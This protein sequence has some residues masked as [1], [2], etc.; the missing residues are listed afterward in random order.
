MIND[1]EVYYRSIG[2]KYTDFAIHN[3]DIFDYK[4][5]KNKIILACDGLRD[6][7][8]NQQAVDIE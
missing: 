3:P 6:V 8:T 1:L 7:L 5:E 2:D 4:I